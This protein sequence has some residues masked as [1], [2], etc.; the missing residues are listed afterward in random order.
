MFLLLFSSLLL[1][2]CRLRSVRAILHSSWNICPFKFLYLSINRYIVISLY[3]SD[4]EDF[5]TLR[6]YLSSKIFLTNFL[7]DLNY[8]K[9]LSDINVA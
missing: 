7:T 2:Y 1:R 6:G 3:L 5:S 4:T 9:N 8:N